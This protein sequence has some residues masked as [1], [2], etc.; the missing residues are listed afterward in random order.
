MAMHKSLVRPFRAVSLLFLSL[1]VGIFGFSYIEGYPL[2]DAFYMTTIT[3]STVGF[4]EVQPLSVDGKLFTAVYIV[5]NF[6]IFAYVVSTLTTHVFE[7]EINKMFKKFLT[8]R[9]VKKLKDHVIVCGYGRNG[10]KACEE[11]QKSNRTFV[12]AEND[13]RVLD[14]LPSDLKIQFISGDATQ[15]DTLKYARIEKAHSI[16]TTLP[17]DSDNVFIT[18]TARELNP[19]IHI[20]A[21]ATEENAA[22]KLY[23]AGA[24]NVVMPDALGGIHMA[25][26]VTRPSVIEFLDILNGVGST[27][28]KLEEF[29]FRQF[30]DQYKN[31]SLGQLNIKKDTGAT[32]VGIKKGGHTFNFDPSADTVIEE[33]DVFIVLGKAEH[34]DSFRKYCH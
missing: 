6:V 23:R 33:D 32:V 4:Q 3:L 28:L 20:I 1:L 15:D 14:N 27:Q 17:S 19:G 21:R 31:K 24:N 11:L 29:S 26:L 16:I 34:I 7:G 2:L 8:S 30:K 12:V 18:L 10:S 5:F 25:N 13:V 22:Q 9:E